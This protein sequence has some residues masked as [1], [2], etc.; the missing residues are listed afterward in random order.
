MTLVS[1]VAKIKIPLTRVINHLLQFIVYLN[2]VLHHFH[3][4][5]IHLSKEKYSSKSDMI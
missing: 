2:E 3:N 5:L 1:F 4:S